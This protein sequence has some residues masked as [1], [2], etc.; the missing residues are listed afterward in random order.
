MCSL[1]PRASVSARPVADVPCP[2]A[3][4]RLTNAHA[5]IN[6]AIVLLTNFIFITVISFSCFGLV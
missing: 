6:E 3:A 2:M 5:K 1:H 4:T